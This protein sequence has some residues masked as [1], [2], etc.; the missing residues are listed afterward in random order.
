MKKHLTLSDF[1]SRNYYIIL[2][3]FLM[4]VIFNNR[5]SAQDTIVMRNGAEFYGQV[6]EVNSSAIL[7]KKAVNSDGP[8]YSE[9]KIDVKV[10]KYKNGMQ[11]IFELVKQEK[12]SE[13]TLPVKTSEP[14]K[15]PV[16][17][18]RG[19]KYLYGN[20]KVKEA[21]MND[22]L[23]DLNNPR[24]TKEVTLA[25]RLKMGQYIGFA[26]IP[27]GAAAIFLF[28]T[29]HRFRDLSVYDEERS[30]NSGAFA[31]IAAGC[32]TTTLTFKIMSTKSNAKAVK[33]YKQ[34]Y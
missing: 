23:L 19:S 30:S 9:D 3:L 5:I 20:Q 32:L 22:I 21:E 34:I 25:K 31:L 8:I 17:V 18:K 24:I 16:L 6:L 28:A 10:I 13:V 27:A 2:F 26:A 12:N 15:N 11:E 1:N 4:L 29:S 14:V 33:L 7:F